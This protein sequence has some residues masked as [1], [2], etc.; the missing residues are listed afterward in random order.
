MNS[1]F[2]FCKKINMD[3][4]YSNLTSKIYT[5]NVTETCAIFGYPSAEERADSVIVQS[6]RGAKTSFTRVRILLEM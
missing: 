1:E 5:K 4:N 6:G 3:H 2:P